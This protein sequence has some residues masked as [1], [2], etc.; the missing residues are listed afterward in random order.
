LYRA[1][2]DLHGPYQ[3]PSEDGMVHFH[4]FLRRHVEPELGT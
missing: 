3:S 1:G 4:E 2:E